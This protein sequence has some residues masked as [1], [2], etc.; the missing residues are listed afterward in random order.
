[1]P[2]YVS[3]LTCD[4]SESPNDYERKLVERDS[5]ECITSAEEY[6]NQIGE[7]KEDRTEKVYDC[8]FFS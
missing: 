5:R 7:G 2:A 4:T 1:M 6:S 3:V 8:Y